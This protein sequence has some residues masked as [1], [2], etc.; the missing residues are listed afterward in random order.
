MSELN[1][2]RRTYKTNNFNGDKYLSQSEFTKLTAPKK[3]VVNKEIKIIKRKK[4]HKKQPPAISY[5]T[6][7]LNKIFKCWLKDNISELEETFECMVCCHEK[8]RGIFTSYKDTM[9]K[10]YIQYIFRSNMRQIRK[11]YS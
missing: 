5:D 10:D 2:V 4:P 6:Y 8:N 11:D 1:I 7:L 9:F 3:T